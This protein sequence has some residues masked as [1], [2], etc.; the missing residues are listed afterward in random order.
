M[1]PFLLFHF[2]GLG[3]WPPSVCNRRLHRIYTAGVRTD[4]VIDRSIRDLILKGEIA[5]NVCP[6]GSINSREPM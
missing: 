5:F 3:A 1:A 6:S 4:E 2:A